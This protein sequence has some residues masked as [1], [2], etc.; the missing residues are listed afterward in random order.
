MTLRTSEESV[1]NEHAH[2]EHVEIILALYDTFFE[3]L[4][5]LV[6]HKVEMNVPLMYEVVFYLVEDL[7]VGLHA[8]LMCALNERLIIKPRYF[9]FCLATITC[10]PILSV[11]VYITFLLVTSRASVLW[12][13]NSNRKFFSHSWIILIVSSNER[14]A[15]SN[16]L[17]T[18][19]VSK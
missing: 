8:E 9:I 15:S 13:A 2:T 18:I 14:L 19:N 11:I 7:C 10:S 4:H 3:R 12:A 17:P 5:I 1:L 16:S 6:H